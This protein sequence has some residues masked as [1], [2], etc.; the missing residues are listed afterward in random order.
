MME[1]V[2]PLARDD[3][4][5]LSEIQVGAFVANNDTTTF[6]LPEFRG[7]RLIGAGSGAGLGSTGRAPNYDLATDADTCT[8]SCDNQHTHSSKQIIRSWIW[9]PEIALFYIHQVDMSP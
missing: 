6:G 9:H 2:F 1:I 5:Q 3:D 8:Q 4:H 7:R